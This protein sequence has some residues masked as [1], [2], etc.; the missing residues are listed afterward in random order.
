M[1]MIFPKFFKI[2]ALAL[3]TLLA[4]GCATNEAMKGGAIGGAVGCAGGAIIAK[5]TG[6]SAAQG[7]AIGGAAGAVVGYMD[8]RKKDLQLAEQIRERIM[9]DAYGTDTQVVVTKRQE[10]VPEA[11]R[12]QANNAKSYETVDKMVVNVPNTLVAKQDARA[13]QTFSR[14]G[15]YVSS[16]TAPATVTINARNPQDYEYIVKSIRS[17]YGKTNPEPQKVKYVFTEL[18]RG[19]QASVEVAHA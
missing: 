18:K 12:A 5:M 4:T 13:A 10:V 19:S 8:G 9:S 6:G 15:N 17:G 14:V 16:A 11:E 1:N 7:C 2:S 3:A